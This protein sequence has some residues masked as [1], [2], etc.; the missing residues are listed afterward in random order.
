VSLIAA[1]R[2]RP[3]DD[4]MT[5]LI[6]ARDHGDRLSEAEL[7]QQA[8]GFLVAGHDTTANQLLVSLLTLFE[9]P[10]QLELLRARPELVPNAVE[11]LLRFSRLLT[12]AFARVA[13]ADVGLEGAAVPAGATVFALTA[14]ANRD[15]RVYAD[16]DRLDVART[17]ATHLAFGAGP[18]VCVGAALARIELQVALASLLRRFPGLAPAAPAPEL[19]WKRGTFVRGVRALPVTW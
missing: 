6:E 17:D 13:T 16:P 12:A 11:E 7:V 15:G 2:E 3:G 8:V 19:D 1:K 10:D 14:S 5:T 18:H 9:H 4:L